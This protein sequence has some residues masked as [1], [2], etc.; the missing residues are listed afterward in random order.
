MATGH[1]FESPAKWTVD[2]DNAHDFGPIWRALKVA[3]K[4]GIRELELVL[5]FDDPQAAVATPFEKFLRGLS[6]SREGQVGG[7][8]ASR[9]AAVA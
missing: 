5:S 6:H 3:H 2:R 1:Y 4:L 9:R 7:R 8:R